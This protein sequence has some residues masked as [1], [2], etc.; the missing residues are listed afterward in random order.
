ME[1]WRGRSW[2]SRPDE[3]GQS[4]D[5]DV[6]LLQVDNR[7]Q[8]VDKGHFEGRTITF[9]DQTILGQ[10]GDDADHHSD[11]SPL[12]A[13][14]LE[15]DQVCGPELTLFEGTA[16]LDHDFGA[17]DLLSTFPVVDSLEGDLKTLVNATQRPHRVGAVVDPDGGSGV[18][19]DD[20][21]GL[22]VETQETLETVGTPESPYPVTGA[23]SRRTRRQL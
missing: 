15:T 5:L 22:Q 23:L 19:V 18:K 16:S 20:V 12:Q 10:T 1:L 8:I 13:A 9:H 3:P 17:P 6:T 14:G 4:H 2:K 21:F 7:D 11:P